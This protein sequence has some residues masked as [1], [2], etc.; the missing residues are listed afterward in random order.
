MTIVF[1]SCSP[2]GALI[3]NDCSDKL[4]AEPCLEP[5][6]PI[7]EI[8]F[9][10][11]FRHQMNRV[12]KAHFQKLGFEVFSAERGQIWLSY[13]CCAL[14]S[15]ITGRPH[16]SVSRWATARAITSAAPPVG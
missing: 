8:A 14:F 15:T 4:F 9:V 12:G 1:A 10:H 7:P 11:L 13:L 16:D 6:A 5:I 2:Y 3:S